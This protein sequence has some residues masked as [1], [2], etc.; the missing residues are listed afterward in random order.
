MQGKKI[1]II[2]DDLAFTE[3]LGEILRDEGAEVIEEH[4]GAAGI[5]R[6]LADHPD[7]LLIDIM[8]PRMSGIAALEKLRADEWGAHVPAILLTNMTQ[9]DALAA[10]MEKG[11]PTEYL[12]KTDWTLDQV[13]DRVKQLLAA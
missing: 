9:P 10:S 2:D 7:I 4:D 5:E 6:A 1:L 8:M 11:P 3:M 13:A 12:L